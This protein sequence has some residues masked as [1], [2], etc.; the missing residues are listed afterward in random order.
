MNT[1]CCW[2]T[3]TATGMGSHRVRR[4]IAFL[5]CLLPVALLGCGG[6][7]GS[8]KSVV[9]GKVTFNG[10]PVPA[11]TVTFIAQNTEGTTMM[12]AIDNGTY[13]IPNFPPGEVK[14]SVQGPGRPSNPEDKTPRVTLPEKYL[15]VMTSG[16]TYTVKTGQQT[17]DLNLTP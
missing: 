13:R 9:T 7:G 8:M 10:A 12:S 5:C 4:A 14:I 16:L 6:S 15:N 17:H 1:V 11:G 2:V 3:W